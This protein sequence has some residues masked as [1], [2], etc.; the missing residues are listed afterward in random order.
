MA[1]ER[2]DDLDH[3]SSV[4]EEDEKLLDSESLDLEPTTS[5][6][7]PRWCS[8]SSLWWLTNAVLLFAVAYLAF[9]LDSTQT[10][11][12]HYELA[13]EVNGVWPRRVSGP[14]RGEMYSMLT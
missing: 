13:G 4:S 8:F 10:L 6:K 5:Y 7:R 1:A 3:R 2:L 9:Q 11:L 12:G 14:P